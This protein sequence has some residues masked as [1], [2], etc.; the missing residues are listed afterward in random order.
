MD[1]C[2]LTESLVIVLLADP[3]ILLEYGASWSML[4]RWWQ[5]IKEFV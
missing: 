5:L 2:S 4:A 3:Q 1:V